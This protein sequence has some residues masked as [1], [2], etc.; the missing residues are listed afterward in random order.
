KP[1][2]EGCTCPQCL[3]AA[4]LV[5][6]DRSI[7]LSPVQQS[8][9][10]HL[11]WGRI[12]V[13][14]NGHPPGCGCPLCTGAQVSAGVAGAGRGGPDTLD[15]LSA[16]QGI[17]PQADRLK[18]AGNI[19]RTTRARAGSDD[20]LVGGEGYDLLVGGFKR[21]G[22]LP[23]FGNAP[24]LGTPSYAADG[25]QMSLMQTGDPTGERIGSPL[26]DRTTARNAGAADWMTDRSGLDLF[27]ASLGDIA[28]EHDGEWV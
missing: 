20:V 17:P 8:L 11:P 21:N 19:I 12:D 18:A 16:Q 3:A 2:G 14:A 10:D 1:G 9:S 26:F 22:L 5:R 28:P 25:A 4:G 23:G 27:F 13:Q 7:A 15:V 24:R 6:A